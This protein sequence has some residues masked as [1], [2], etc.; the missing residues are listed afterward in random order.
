MRVVV[1]GSGLIGLS[2]AATLAARGLRP[3]ILDVG[4]ELDEQRKAVVDRL[5]SL[6]IGQLDVAERELVTA[7]D[8]FVADVLPKKLH[9][10]SDYI[11]ASSRAFAPIHTLAPGRVAFPTFA[12]GGFSNIWGSAVLPVD[13]C[14]MADWPVSHAE[15]EPYFRA[16]AALL[17]ITGGE[18]TLSQ[19][20]PGYRDRLGELD[21]G[22]QGLALLEDLHRAEARL[23]RA[24]TLYGRAR[25]AVYTEAD[26]ETGAAACINCGECFTGCARGSIFSSVPVLTNMA[27][28]GVVEYRRGFYVERI[29]EN[30][31]AVIVHGTSTDRNE[32]VALECDAVFVAAGTLNTTRILLAS[33]SLFDTPVRFKESQKFA[34]PLLRIKAR[35]TAIESPSVTL[36]SA[37]I[38]TKVQA[39]SDHWLHIQ[40]VPLNETITTGA[41]IPTT[42][43]AAAVLRP[44]TRRLM[45]AWC[46][47]HSD[48]SSWVEVILQRNPTGGPHIFDLNHGHDPVAL[49]A[50]H[51]AGYDLLRKGLLFKTLFLPMKMKIA[52][53]GSGTHSGGSFPMRTTPSA[54]LDT[55]VLGRPFGWSRVFAVDS[56]VLPS[57]PGT[58]LAFTAM[59]NAAR[60]ASLA[61]LAA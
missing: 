56:S 15:M 55:D 45:V 46:G 23:A 5:K 30:G 12:K 43:A 33:G 47:M 50:A 18:G 22:P 49:K 61:P 17:P 20:F 48:H 3:V 39:L 54:R 58:T 52:N 7:N 8:T 26:P 11:Y 6:S 1:I 25:L 13:A 32:T 29:E 59:A 19:A 57:I 37:F 60:I 53:P 31:A 2:A 14:D 16:T 10:G 38:E 44:L 51:T 9:F 28:K 24:D 42:G 35:P 21:P 36:A 41:R 4:E 34:I 27:A 40:V